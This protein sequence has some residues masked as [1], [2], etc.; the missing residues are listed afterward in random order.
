MVLALLDLAGD[1]RLFSVV[2]H[3]A[4]EKA[5]GRGSGVQLPVRPDIPLSMAAKLVLRA[6]PVAPTTFDHVMRWAV[7][8]SGPW[9]IRPPVTRMYVRVV[10]SARAPPLDDFCC[11]HDRMP[12]SLFESKSRVL[13]VVL[14]H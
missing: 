7:G 6:C 1:Y 12:L 13:L 3:A 5:A 11:G 10:T 14:R 9:R 2:R 4:L 8:V